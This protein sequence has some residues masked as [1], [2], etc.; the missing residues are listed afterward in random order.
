MHDANLNASS[1]I[2][3]PRLIITEKNKH[4]LIIGVLSSPIVFLS[5]FRVI[6]FAWIFVVICLI[7]IFYLQQEKIIDYLKWN[8]SIVQSWFAS[9][10]S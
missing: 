2:Q 4:W 6:S 8:W 10:P 7:Y 5:L 9:T 1:G 3:D